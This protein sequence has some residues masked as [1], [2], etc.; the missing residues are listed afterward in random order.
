MQIFNSAK[1]KSLQRSQQIK[2]QDPLQYFFVFDFKESKSIEVLTQKHM[3]L[4]EAKKD[5]LFLEQGS[6]KLLPVDRNQIIMRVENLADRFDKS[7]TQTSFLNIEK[8]AK[9]LYQEINGKKA[10]SVLIEEVSIQGTLLEKDRAE[11]TFKCTGVDDGSQLEFNT[12]P[13]DKD[14]FKGVAL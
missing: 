1:G 12:R 5:T 6:I 3:S 11:T 10:A 7:S 2:L 14:G 9:D 8:L 4:A 13:A